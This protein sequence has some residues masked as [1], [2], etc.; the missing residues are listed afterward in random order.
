MLPIVENV[1]RFLDT[2]FEG[3]MVSL[4]RDLAALWR[5]RTPLTAA[6]ERV[7]EAAADAEDSSERLYPNDPSIEAFLGVLGVELARMA[8]PLGA[9]SRAITTAAIGISGTLARQISLPREQD[10]LWRVITIRDL[11]NAGLRDY[12]SRP[13]FGRMLRGY[14]A[15]SVRQV[16]RGVESAFARGTSPRLLARLLRTYAQSMPRN[17]A[18]VIARTLQLQTWRDATML[19]YQANSH[20]VRYM[21]RIAALD[22]RTCLACVALHGTRLEHGESLSDHYNGRCTAIGVTEFVR[23]DIETGEEW[24][25]RQPRD[26][27]Q[28]LMGGAA[29]R[30]WMARALEL[31]DFVEE[32][33]DPL[34]GEMIREASLRG[35]LGEHAHKYYRGSR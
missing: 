3:G 4:L 16:Q 17:R 10:A 5:G 20:I 12:L 28:D 31:M 18:L 7:A 26:F 29:W 21:I 9:A 6:Y 27:Q 34:F 1:N 30:A 25:R 22:G 33:N 2:S 11:L 32:V 23:R 13:A 19:H 15:A 24:L 14:G 8:N 35:I